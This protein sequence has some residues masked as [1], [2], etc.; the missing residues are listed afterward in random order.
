MTGR[1]SHTIGV[2]GVRDVKGKLFTNKNYIARI[3]DMHLRQRGL[4]FAAVSLVTGGGHGVEQLVV[5]WCEA[6]KIEVR[7]FP[8]N[9]AEYGT[10]RAF[11]IRNNTVVAESDELIV[12]WDGRIDVPIESIATAMHLQKQATVYPVKQEKT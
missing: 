7:K 6:K 9:I 10:R 11:H 5:E 4:T 1:K 12:F 3:L 2:V 8:P